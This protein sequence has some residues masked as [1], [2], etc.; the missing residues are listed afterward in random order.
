VSGTRRQRDRGG[1]NGAA[2]VEAQL[3]CFRSP[4]AGASRY[5]R[6]PLGSAKETNCAGSITRPPV[7]PLLKGANPKLAVRTAPRLTP[8]ALSDIV[9]RMM[10]TVTTEDLEWLENEGHSVDPNPAVLPDGRKLYDVDG[11][12]YTEEEIVRHLTEGSTLRR[13]K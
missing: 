13:D 7:H 4:T 10:Y 9:P 2:A 12:P 3:Y 11:L 6:H 5:F 8:A 1:F